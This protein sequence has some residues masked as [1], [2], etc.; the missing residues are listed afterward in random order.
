MKQVKYELPSALKEELLNNPFIGICI[1]DGNG[2]VLAVNDA[3]TKITALSWDTFIGTTMADLVEKKIVSIS[4]T[5]EVLKKKEPVSLHQS[6]SNG[7]SYEVSARPVFNDKKEIIYVVSYLLDMTTLVQAQNAIEQLHL[8]KERIKSKY[9]QLQES[10]G[11]QGS[12]IYQSRC[13]SNIVELTKRVAKTQASVLITGPTGAGKEVIASILH[14]KSCHADKP[15]I[16][17][18]CS[19]IPESLLE[20]ELFGYEPGTFTGSN[21]KG[22]K[23]LFECA[24]GGSLLLDEIGEMPLNLQ[25]KLLRVLQDQSVRKVGGSNTVQ[26]NVRIIASTNACLK[27]LI[28]EKK[29]REDLYYR[30]NVIE[31]NIPALSQRK[32]DIPLLT[33]H[34]IRIFNTKYACNKKIS[35]EALN[36]LHAKEYS[37]NVRELK[38]IVERLVVQSHDDMINIKDVLEAFGVLK[39]SIDDLPLLIDVENATSLKEIMDKYERQVLSEYLKAYGNPSEIAKKLNTDRTTISRKL[40]KHGLRN[41]L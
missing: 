30:L 3:Q 26:V 14:E 10:F 4:S 16:K 9:E 28:K 27:D 19:A 6:L 11:R 25:S 21:Q 2:L 1:A 5:V 15:F 7:R 13:M 40:T 24:D 41:T 20:S 36:Y 12:A 8:D 38:N 18:N 29:F 32:E 34:F 23:G 31:I 17:I 39:M 33:E 37:G 35:P 22:K